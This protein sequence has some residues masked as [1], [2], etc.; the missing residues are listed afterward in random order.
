[1]PQGDVLKEDA[2]DVRYG[3]VR[4]LRKMIEHDRTLGRRVTGHEALRT[5]FKEETGVIEVAATI[6]EP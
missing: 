5:E 2:K 6:D 4:H 1:M 3:G